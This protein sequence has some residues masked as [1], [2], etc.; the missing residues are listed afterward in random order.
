MITLVCEKHVCTQSK[1]SEAG[2]WDGCCGG[3]SRPHVAHFGRPQ[4]LHIRADL[5]AAYF[6]IHTATPRGVAKHYA[7]TG[8][9]QTLHRPTRWGEPGLQIELVG[10]G[11]GPSS[12]DAGDSQAEHAR[13]RA[14]A[15]RFK[16]AYCP[17]PIGCP[18]SFPSL[19]PPTPE[20]VFHPLFQISFNYSHPISPVGPPS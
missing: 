13:A 2:Q 8:R 14:R 6:C 3:T 20:S 18:L 4:V 5:A 11:S 19:P 7:H 16:P 9:A 12:C 17:S 15:S 1:R 10:G